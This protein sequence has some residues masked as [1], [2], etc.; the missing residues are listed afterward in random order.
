MTISRALGQLKEHWFVALFGVLIP[1]ALFS[2]YVG[3]PIVYNVYLSFMKWNG[4][5]PR[6]QPIG[7]QNYLFLLQSAGFWTSFFNSVKWLVGTV[8]IANVF[9]LLFAASLQARTVY[10]PTL[11]RSLTFLPV[12]MA[13]VSIGLMFAYILDPN[14]GMVDALMR[15]FGGHAPKEGL[16]GN[17]HAALYTLIAIFGWSYLGIPLMIYHAGISQIPPELYESAW[18]EG[19]GRAQVMRYVTLP[20]LRSVVVIVTIYSVIEGF[21]NFDLIASVTRGGPGDAT[22]VLGYYLYIEAF[23][24]RFFGIGAAVSVVILVLSVAFV[25]TYL[26]RVGEDTL[27]A[28]EI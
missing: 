20:A 14:F 17:P 15:A 26:K 12:T 24:E 8:V 25:A 2:T 22:D 3:Y 23:Q 18:L 27:H 9:G 19:A 28:S 7:L 6:L 11:F 10:L 13:L 5:A 21:R 4:F 1:M 16:L